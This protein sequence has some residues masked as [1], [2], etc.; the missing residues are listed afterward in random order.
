MVHGQVFIA[1]PLRPLAKAKLAA[2]EDLFL[3]AS[4]NRELWIVNHSSKTA[5]LKAMELCGLNTGGFVQKA[6]GRSIR[7]SSCGICPLIK[8]AP[9]LTPLLR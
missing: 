3:V 4:E 8:F 9:K 1:A 6:A 7:T 5:D 2:C